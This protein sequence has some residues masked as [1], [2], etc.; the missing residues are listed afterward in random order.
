MSNCDK[1]NLD[2]CDECAFKEKSISEIIDNISFVIDDSVKGK[3]EIGLMK[4]ELIEE[5][6]KYIKKKYVK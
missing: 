4:E 6:N 5:I 2:T 1:C 3:T